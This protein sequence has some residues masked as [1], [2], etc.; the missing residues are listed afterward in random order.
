MNDQFAL[1]ANPPSLSPTHHYCFN[2]NF[3][4][5]TIFCILISVSFILQCLDEQH[6]LAASI[7]NKKF[8]SATL[9]PSPP[10][11]SLLFSH[12]FIAPPAPIFDLR[13]V[14]FEDDIITLTWIN[15]FDGFSPILGATVE[16]TP[17]EG[18]AMT[19]NVSLDSLMMTTLPNL[20]PSTNY[21][22]NV[23]L[24]NM[25]GHGDAMSVHVQTR[26]QRKLIVSELPKD[27]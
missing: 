4:C 23:S 25:V 10:P 20:M 22:I 9:P 7:P 27:E 26:R 11:L 24:F 16:Y 2:I 6:C 1:L 21:T 17:E 8:Q 14:T 12:K 13:N 5:I 19:Q 15:G 18:F 3:C